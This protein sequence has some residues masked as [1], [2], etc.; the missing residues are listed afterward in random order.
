MREECLSSHDKVSE[1]LGSICC[2]SRLLPI[3]CISHQ[4]NMLIPCNERNVYWEA[5]FLREFEVRLPV[6]QRQMTSDHYSYPM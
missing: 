2:G 6:H 5:T 1:F 4:V 3:S